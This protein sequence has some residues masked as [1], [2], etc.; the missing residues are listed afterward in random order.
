MDIRVLGFT[1]PDGEVR[2]QN[3]ILGFYGLQ[4]TSEDAQN[5]LKISYMHVSTGTPCVLQVEATSEGR[6]QADMHEDPMVL[7]LVPTASH[8]CI[9]ELW[10]RKVQPDIALEGVIHMRK[11]LLSCR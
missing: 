4:S 1:A 11:L 10:P 7:L 5:F 8:E 9:P 6:C 2:T 3:S